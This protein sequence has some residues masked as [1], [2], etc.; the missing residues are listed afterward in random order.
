MERTPGGREAEPAALVSALLCLPSSPAIQS[1]SASRKLLEK[2]KTEGEREA[3][4][5][6]LMGKCWG[7][8]AESTEVGRG[9]EEG[10][11]AQPGPD[12]LREWDGERGRAQVTGNR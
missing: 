11:K 6:A 8:R 3:R 7:Q 1:D 2:E 10:E 9:G 4:Q 5:S 12:R